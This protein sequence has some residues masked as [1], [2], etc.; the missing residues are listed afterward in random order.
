MV[1][2]AHERTAGKGKEGVG[3]RLLGEMEEKQARPSLLGYARRGSRLR[4]EREVRK[5][6]SGPDREK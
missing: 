5:R 4:E 6:L 2:P 1:G 3:Q